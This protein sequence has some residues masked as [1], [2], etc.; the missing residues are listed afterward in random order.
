[1]AMFA[2][3]ATPTGLAWF[4]D[5][6]IVALW[7]GNPPRLVSVDPVTGSVGDWASGFKDPIALLADPDGSLLVIDFLAGTITRITPLA[8]ISTPTT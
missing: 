1:M 4:A 2:P 5:R 6:L 7:N 3:E 8:A